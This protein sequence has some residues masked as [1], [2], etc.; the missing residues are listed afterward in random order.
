[1]NILY[2]F[3]DE[4]PWDVRVE[5]I[6]NSLARHH[7]VSILCRNR[8]ALKDAECVGAVQVFRVG[9]KGLAS[10]KGFPAFFSPW[11]ISA[12]LR[13]IRERAIDMVIVRDLPMSP[14]ALVLRK[15]TGV[16][17][18]FDMAEDYP[19]MIQDTWKYKG[20]RLTDYVI[21]NPYFL[22]LLENYVLRRIDAAWV[23]SEAS[24]ARIAGRVKGEITVVGNTPTR[25]ILELEPKAARE[26]SNL[27]VIYT[28]WVDESRGVDTV[29][30][31]IGLS[32][33]EGLDVSLVVVG[34]G[35]MIDSLKRL[36]QELQIESRVTFLGWQ[37]QAEL[38]RSIMQSDVGIV[39]HHVTAH[40]DTTLPNKIFGYMALA[41]PVIASD[42]AALV[43]IVQQTGCGLIFIDNDAETLV[44]CFRQL[45]TAEVRE[46]MGN[47][48]RRAVLERF[49]WSV[50]EQVMI[51]AV[52]TWAPNQD[53]ASQTTPS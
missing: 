16:P 52:N 34:A 11:W 14:A 7:D 42:A 20:P 31:A 29:V 10:I 1:M 43:D 23:V 6:T 26:T 41:R 21:R 28:G 44:N 3:Q 48:G 35:T 37:S 8:G 30:R 49:N 51:K 2:I 32:Q 9:G 53:G 13:V 27:S 25:D 4:Y 40:T 17:V 45:G 22:R 18:I 12:G 50:D 24:Q 46:Q 5:K 38:R 36:V 15:L 39:P 19:A 47:S 33:E